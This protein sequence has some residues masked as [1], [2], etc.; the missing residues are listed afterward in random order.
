MGF[1]NPRVRGTRGSERR[2]HKS[3]CFLFALLLFC[4]DIHKVIGKML[5]PRPLNVTCDSNSQATTMFD[6]SN[7]GSKAIL[8]HLSWSSYFDDGGK[9][10]FPSIFLSQKALFSSL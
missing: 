7:Y 10:S 3:L 6:R 5:L 2:Y 9:A 1:Y 8:N 4:Q